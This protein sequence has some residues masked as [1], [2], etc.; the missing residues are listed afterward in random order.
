MSTEI[1]YKLQLKSSL[2]AVNLN[3][4]GGYNVANGQNHN[5]QK[6]YGY[7]HVVNGDKSAPGT[8]FTTTDNLKDAQN[9]IVDDKAWNDG[10]KLGP[11]SYS[12]QGIG[13]AVPGI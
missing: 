9:N 1:Q 12:V 13:E 8:P 11:N 7:N 5:N 4:V 3:Q 2:Q 6:Q 10:L